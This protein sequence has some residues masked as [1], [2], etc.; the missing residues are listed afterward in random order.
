MKR[1]LISGFLA[2][3][4]S[5]PL[6]AKVTLTEAAAATTIGLNLLEIRATTAKAVKAWKATKRVTVKAAKKV[7]GKQSTNKD[8]TQ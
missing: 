1:V 5:C 7:A 4:L 3:W 6:P 8:K 2:F